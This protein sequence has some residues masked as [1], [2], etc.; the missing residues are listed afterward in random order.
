MPVH[1]K[2][3]FRMD[4]APNF[5]L[6]DGPGRLMKLLTQTYPKL[7]QSVHEVRDERRV[8]ASF[9]DQKSEYVSHREIWTDPTT[10]TF[11]IEDAAGI[12]LNAGVATTIGKIT[13]ILDRLADD[14]KIQD[15]KRAGFR[16]MTLSNVAGSPNA[17][18]GRIRGLISESITNLVEKSGSIDD[19][20]ITFEGGI[21]SIRYRAQFGPYFNIKEHK[22]FFPKIE[23]PSRRMVEA[24]LI[25][26]LDL[27]EHDLSFKGR[28]PSNWLRLQ[29]SSAEKYC[30]RIS[31]LIGAIP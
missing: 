17:V 6:V 18:C 4:F 19:L 28:K 5:D 15:L 23:T 30:S 14:F 2:A 9:S 29:M 13:E 12:E 7:W 16:V 11:V 27:F 20:G 22:K 1:H 25:C 3:T 21:D 31:K 26:D 10:I 8:G 24:D